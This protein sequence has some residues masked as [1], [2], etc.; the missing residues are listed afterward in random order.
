[1]PTALF[2]IHEL[3]NITL[4]DR[5]K[6]NTMLPT[7][8]AESHYAL[9]MAVAL[10]GDQECEVFLLRHLYN[11]A[12]SLFWLVALG[13]NFMSC[14]NLCERL[15]VRTDS[16]DWSCFMKCEGRYHMLSVDVQ[17]AGSFIQNEDFW[18]SDQHS[19]Y[20]NTLLLS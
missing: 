16:C 4:I 18:I 12:C 20:S 3:I 7:N 9:L 6:S 1:M 8:R 14:F 13:F 5:G 2:H 17:V 15:S 11:N 10:S 19:S